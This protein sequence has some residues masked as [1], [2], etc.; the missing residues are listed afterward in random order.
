MSKAVNIRKHTTMVQPVAVYG[1][2][3]RSVRDG[4]EKTEYMG[5]ENIKKDIWTGGRTRTVGNKN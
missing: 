3:T 4:Y 5:D 1:S 2:E